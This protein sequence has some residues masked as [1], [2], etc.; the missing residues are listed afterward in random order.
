MAGSK[1]STRTR[2]QGANVGVRLMA[3]NRHDIEALD[4]GVLRHP[5]YGRK[6]WV[7]QSVAQRWFSEPIEHRAPELRDGVRRVIA[8]IARKIERTI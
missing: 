1:F 4:K 8:D 2:A 7:T 3:T 6:K 5:V